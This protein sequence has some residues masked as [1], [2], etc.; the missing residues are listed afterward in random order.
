MLP[1]L[2]LFYRLH[3][4]RLLANERR[5]AQLRDNTELLEHSEVI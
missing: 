2:G 4:D 5:L 3:F 1:M